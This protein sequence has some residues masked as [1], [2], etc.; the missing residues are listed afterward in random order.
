MNC[1]ELCTAAARLLLQ[2]YVILF[3]VGERDTEG[4]YS[5]RAFDKES[6]LPNETIILFEQVGLWAG[7]SVTCLHDW[8]HG[9]LAASPLSAAAHYLG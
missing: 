2:V 5:L 8:A 6:G 9:P 4:I 7:A 1:T 3:G